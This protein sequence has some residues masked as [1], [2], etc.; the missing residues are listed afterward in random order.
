MRIVLIYPPPGKI[1]A[2]EESPDLLK[3][4]P[5]QKY[6]KDT[7]EDGDIL[8][9][10]YGLLS[11]AAQAIR[12]GHD[13]LTFNLSSFPWLQS[14]LLIRNINANLFGLSCHTYNLRGMAMIAKLIRE[15]HPKAHIVCGGPFVTAVPEKTLKHFQEIDTI[16]IGEG[17]ETFLELIRHLE[18][19]KSTDGLAGTVCRSGDSILI[20]PPRKRIDD[21]DSLASPLDFFK[22]HTLVY[23]APLGTETLS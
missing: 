19:G 21:L 8:C 10:P 5:L 7:I 22:L 23:T 13:V 17:E 16:V 1:L 3:E 20:G 11:L 2:P 4:T 14:E 6:V 9:S 12:A 15:A 18:A